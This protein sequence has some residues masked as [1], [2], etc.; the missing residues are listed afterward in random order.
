MAANYN[1][2]WKI[3]IDRKLKRTDLRDL[4]GISTTTVAKLGKDE[5]VSMECMNRICNWYE[6][7]RSISTHTLT[8]SVTRR[9][10][11]I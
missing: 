8:W 7:P 3:L 5:Y 11:E 4:A 6:L 1:K 10:N 2:L 9:R